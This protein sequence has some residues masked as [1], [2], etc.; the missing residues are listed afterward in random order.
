MP[1]LNQRRQRRKQK[2][3]KKR[4]VKHSSKKEKIDCCYSCG[5]Y[6]EVYEYSK[7][8]LKKG[9]RGKCNACIYLQNNPSKQYQIPKIISSQTTYQTQ[10][11]KP[12]EAQQNIVNI[13][14]KFHVP[15][16][17]YCQKSSI[18]FGNP[19]LIVF[20]FIRCSMDSIPNT[21][22]Q[23]CFK[24]FGNDAVYFED[25]DYRLKTSNQGST[26]TKVNISSWLLSRAIIERV[27]DGSNIIITSWHF[28][29]DECIDNKNNIAFI[30]LQKPKDTQNRFRAGKCCS[31]GYNSCIFQKG[32]NVE[33]ILD[34]LEKKFVYKINHHTP[35]LICDF[36][37]KWINFVASKYKYKLA[38]ELFNP[39]DSISIKTMTDYNRLNQ[40]H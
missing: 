15:K 22:M 8:Q 31:I 9:S 4:I 24:Y 17:A 16:K 14:K 40:V 32:D 7:T 20:G 38:V 21:L 23:I 27:I 11:K 6:R 34:L 3:K 35:V 39:N 28:Y 29:L 13:L 33:I 1:S 25:I 26:L 19:Q 36:K 5:K 18:R 37:E 30:L 2:D 12:Y 10:S